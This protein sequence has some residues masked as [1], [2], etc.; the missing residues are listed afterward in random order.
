RIRDRI[1]VRPRS[2]ESLIH[3]LRT[4]HEGAEAVLGPAFAA[5]SWELKIAEATYVL[6]ARSIIERR[7]GAG[8]RSGSEWIVRAA[9]DR[10]IEAMRNGAAP[11][12]AFTI[13][14]DDLRLPALRRR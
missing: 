1:V 6:A 8:L 11:G 4:S 2:L 12:T 13:A 10:L 7:G 9:K 5:H 14:P 3:L